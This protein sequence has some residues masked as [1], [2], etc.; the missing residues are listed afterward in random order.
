MSA[1]EKLGR[2]ILGSLVLGVLVGLAN[3]ALDVSFPRFHAVR[4]TTVLNDLIIGAAAGLLTYIW[5]TRQT[6]RHALEL[7]R[8]RLTHEAIHNERKRMALDL[9]DT[10]CQAHAAAIMHLECT[11]DSPG[12]NSEAREHL[13]RA[14]QLIRG[15]TTEMRCVLW[16]LYP[17]EMHKVDLQTAVEYLAKNLTAG[18]GLNVHVSTEGT[19]RRLP[20][21][22]ESGLIRI[23]HEALSNVVR[24]AQAHE[25]CIELL[26]DS[27]QARLRV[28]DDGKGFRPEPGPGTFGLA[29]MENRTKALGGTWE[30]HSEPGRGTEIRASVPVPTV[31][32]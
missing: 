30:I 25:V 21:N 15:A 4:A 32:T 3:F 10:V 14:L 12:M 6:V 23:S 31:A 16:D 8:E 13:N 29:S 24:H 5:V 28:K 7:S 22:V 1:D 20:P 9:H 19:V 27:A 18:T 26:L 2:R 11:Q 17:E